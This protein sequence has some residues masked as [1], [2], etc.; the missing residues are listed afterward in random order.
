[1]TSAASTVTSSNSGV[2]RQWSD[3]LDGARHRQLP[4]VVAVPTEPHQLIED[5]RLLELRGALIG[6]SHFLR[7]G[8]TLT[9]R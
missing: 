5:F 2:G 3:Q 6:T 7:D 8:V 9:H 4:R 1:M